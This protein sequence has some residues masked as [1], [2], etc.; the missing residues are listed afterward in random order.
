VKTGDKSR[1]FLGAMYV[2]MST[3]QLQT[4]R[5]RPPNCWHQNESLP[6][7]TNLTYLAI[8]QHLFGA[9]Y[10]CCWGLS[11]RGPKSQHC[12]YFLTL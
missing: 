12:R 10:P 6:Y 3:S 7:L 8:T 11:G 4:F 2:L 9:T 5:C 1:I